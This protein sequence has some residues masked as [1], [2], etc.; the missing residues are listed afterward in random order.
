MKIECWV[1]DVTAVG[2]PD[3]SERAILGVILAWHFFG[4]FRPYLLSGNY[5]VM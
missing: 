1:A 4:Q 2:S 5:F 3:I